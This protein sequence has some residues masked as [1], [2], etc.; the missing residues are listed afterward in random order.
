M[1]F[2]TVCSSFKG[3]KYVIQELEDPKNIWNFCQTQ[4]NSG[5]FAKPRK[6]AKKFANPEKYDL[7]KF[8]TQKNRTSIPV[9][10]LTCAPPPGGSLEFCNTSGAIRK[11]L[12][13]HW[14]ITKNL[15]NLKNFQRP[16]PVKNDTFLN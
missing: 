16:L 10:I 15:Q 12:L 14:G 8:Q 2:G 1:F 6:I 11:I 3:F 9:K 4:K 5:N 13:I 7:A